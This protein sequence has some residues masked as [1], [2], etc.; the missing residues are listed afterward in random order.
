MFKYFGDAKRRRGKHFLPL[1]AALNG[2]EGRDGCNAG[3]TLRPMDNVPSWRQ[4]ITLG[5]RGPWQEFL[6]WLSRHSIGGVQ[7][8]INDDHVSLKEVLA[9]RLHRGL[10]SAASFT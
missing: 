10:G 9:A 3:P 2:I 7:M 4:R 5:G 6:A 8:V 1:P